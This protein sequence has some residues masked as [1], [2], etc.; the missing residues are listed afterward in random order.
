[1][2][3]KYFERVQSSSCKPPESLDSVGD[4]SGV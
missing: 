1:M 4:G 3:E 2:T